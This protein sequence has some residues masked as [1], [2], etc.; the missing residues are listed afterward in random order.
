MNL[1]YN[2]VKCLSSSSR[3]GLI[4]VGGDD[5]SLFVVSHQTPKFQKA[6]SSARVF[7][8]KEN[9]FQFDPIS[10]KDYKTVREE[11]IKI[12]KA[13]EREQLRQVR[14]EELGTIKD[15]LKLIL[16]QN[17]NAEEPDQLDR[18]DIVLDL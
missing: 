12:A 5:G 17:E 10:V 18:N 9:D 4:Y 6:V 15:S 8:A 16:E 3:S 1:K 7:E 14:M 11:E 2:G 13:K